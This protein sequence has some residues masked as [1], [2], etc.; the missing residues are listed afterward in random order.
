MSITP[1]H[2]CWKCKKAL[3]RETYCPTCTKLKEK[4][5]YQQRN[6][7]WQYL[8]GSRWQ[9]ER[10]SFLKRNP[11]CVMCLKNGITKAANVVDHRTP[12]KGDK[13]KFWD[14]GN[15]QALCKP[16]HDAKTAKEG[17]FGR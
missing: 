9:R 12:H 4:Q 3:T 1:L 2:P 17:A 6:K 10:L 7:E 16:C 15:W 14:R 8:Y 13:E 5:Y 11:L